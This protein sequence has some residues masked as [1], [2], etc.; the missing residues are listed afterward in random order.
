MHDLLQPRI[1]K[2][3]IWYEVYLVSRR[4][5]PLSNTNNHAAFRYEG[6]NH[7]VCTVAQIRH[8]AARG[9]PLPLPLRIQEKKEREET[10]THLARWHLLGSHENLYSHAL[11]APPR[12]S[13]SPE[14]LLFFV[15]KCTAIASVGVGWIGTRQ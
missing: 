9:A 13:K 5:H 15:A 7:T 4:Q 12:G 14:F 8:T 3:T 6:T 10:T 2:Q 11:Q 1:S